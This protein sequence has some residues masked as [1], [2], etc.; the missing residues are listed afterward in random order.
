MAQVFSQDK[1]TPLQKQTS[2][3]SDLFTNFVV[4]PDLHD[5]VL[6]KD[7]GA[8]KQSIRNLILTDKYE[9]LFQPTIGSNIRR[10]LFELASPLTQKELEN[11][12]MTTIINH[13]P[14]A[15]NVSVV[16]TPNPDENAYAITVTFFPINSSTPETLS[17]L[18]F[19]VR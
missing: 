13:E 4:H 14:R 11:D 12:I 17:T 8:V 1:F 16:V 10:K 3:Y 18:L 5:V 7:A 9:R 2:L 15:Q 6:K 19:R